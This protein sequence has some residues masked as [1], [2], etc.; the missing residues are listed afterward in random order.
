MPQRFTGL[1]RDREFLKYWTASAISDV[2]SQVTALALPLI[3]ALT[4]AAT[5]WQMGALTAAGTA[6][7]LWSASSRACSS[8]GCAGAPC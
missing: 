6:P 1:W 3:A 4:L 5:P 2:G 8:T 7:I